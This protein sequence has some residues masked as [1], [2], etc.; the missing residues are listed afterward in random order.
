MGWGREEGWSGG[1]KGRAGGEEEGGGAL[2]L[3]LTR[4]INMRV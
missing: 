1:G 4:L 3:K 2:S